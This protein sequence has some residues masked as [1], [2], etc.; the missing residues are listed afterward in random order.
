MNEKIS[1]ERKL[2]GSCTA[3]PL[4]LATT[5]KLAEYLCSEFDFELNPCVGYS[6][7]EH[8][9][10]DGY[11]GD[12][13]Y[14]KLQLSDVQ[15]RARENASRI[16]AFLSRSAL[17][18]SQSA[19]CTDCENETFPVNGRCPCGS[20]RVIASQSVP[21]P[22]TKMSVEIGNAA[23]EYVHPRIHGDMRLSVEACR[24]IAVDA[25][26]EGAKMQ[27]STPEI[28]ALRA[29]NERLKADVIAFAGPW[30]VEYAR[31]HQLPKNSLH[32]THYDLLARCGARMD[33]FSRAAVAPEQEEAK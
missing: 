14:V 23:R 32:P 12:G 25:F 9:N 4:D 13:Q 20:G 28:A 29:E 33:D 10:D 7:P 15:A 1:I 24:L 21:A 2:S 3:A 8:S 19:Y 31:L 16:I 30:A 17:S 11:R 18:T 27:Q 6:W 26:R 22:E 5:E